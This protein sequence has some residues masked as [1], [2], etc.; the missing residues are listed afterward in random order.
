MKISFKMKIVLPVLISVLVAFIISSLV[1]FNSVKK[2]SIKVATISASHELEKY[3]GSLSGDI[4]SSIHVAKTLAN[5][6]EIT[7]SVNGKIPREE[8]MQL[9][10]KVLEVNTALFDSWIVWE[11]NQYSPDDSTMGEDSY[12]YKERFSPM[13]YREGNSIAKAHTTIVDDNSGI[14]DWYYKPLKSGKLNI[15]KPTTYEIGGKD[16]ALITISVPF[17]VNGKVIGVAGVDMAISYFKDLVNSIKF[18]DS[19]FAFLLTG[20]YTVFAHPDKSKEGKSF[21]GEFPQAFENSKTNKNSTIIMQTEKGDVLYSFQPF[22]I[23]ETDFRLNI[24]MNVPVAEVFA[25]LTPIKIITSIIVFI[26][27]LIISLIIYVI[28]SKLVKKLGGEPD[29]VIEIM[30]H[31]SKGDF[32]REIKV[33]RND[34]FSLVYSVNQMVSELKHLLRNIIE[35]AEALKDTSADLSS[36]A[37]ELSAGT[38][39]QSESSTQIASAT[40]EMTQTTQQIA[41]NL[42]DISVYSTETNEKALHSKESVNESINGVIKIKDTVD[43]SSLLVAELSVSSDQIIEIVS[44]ISDIADQTNLLALNAA[45]EAARAGD[46]GRGFAVVA[47]EVRK[48]AERTQTATTEISELVNSTQKGIKDVTTSMSDVKT[49]VD[50]GVKMTEQ[51][52]T[53]L[54]V[55]VESVNSLQ[56]MVSSISAATSEMASTSGQIQMDIDAVATVSEEI[57]LTA[58]HIAESSSNLE[59]M[60]DNM[61]DLVKQFKI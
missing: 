18:Y 61:K 6:A 46:Q 50:I 58:N 25:F 9:L 30:S 40:A 38:V 3:A 59:K 8:I 13:A 16:V 49:N 60:S 17:K 32:S 27:I 36:G 53:S 37:N 41:Q 20:D 5:F 39:S 57:T 48:L 22:T 42:S 11:P 51:V 54:D 31:I 26:S 1:I 24:G 4:R 7:S 2:E 15:T 21:S 28:V 10:I 29:H 56:E 55:I 43:S 34:N 44:V 33:A 12:V 35:N 23:A 47:D 52:A 19:G 14:D 45:I